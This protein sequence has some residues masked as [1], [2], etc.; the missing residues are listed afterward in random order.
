MGLST[1]SRQLTGP[2][3]A[4]PSGW[5]ERAASKAFWGQGDWC[6]RRPANTWRGTRQRKREEKSKLDKPTGCEH[7]FWERCFWANLH[8]WKNRKVRE[9]FC[10][11]WT[12]SAF[13]FYK[14]TFQ[15]LNPCLSLRRGGGWQKLDTEKICRSIVYAAVSVTDLS[16]IV[17]AVYFRFQI[18]LK[19]AIGFGCFSHCLPRK[20]NFRAI[21]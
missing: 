12:N 4:G 15:C 11:R 5:T 1:P 14:A 21:S 17:H 13:F 2:Q 18:V 19:D 10:P 3:H 6:T 20:D 8:T 9:G 16:I 7:L